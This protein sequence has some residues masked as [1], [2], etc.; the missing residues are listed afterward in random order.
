MACQT[1]KYQSFITQL[2]RKKDTVLKLFMP[3]TSSFFLYSYQQFS[4]TSSLSLRCFFFYLSLNLCLI[5]LYVLWSFSPLFHHFFSFIS[6]FSLLTFLFTTMCSQFVALSCTLTSCQTNF[7][8]L[9][10]SIILFCLNGTFLSSANTKKIQFLHSLSP[11]QMSVWIRL[12]DNRLPSDYY[13]YPMKQSLL[14]LALLP[15]LLLPSVSL[16]SVQKKL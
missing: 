13:F 4:L 5:C 14:P 2:T 9:T 8:F 7:S 6:S 11:F 16:E 15:L 12:N 10:F 1:F 3:A